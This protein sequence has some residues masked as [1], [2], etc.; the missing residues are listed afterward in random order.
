MT[1]DRR[2]QRDVEN[3]LRRSAERARDQG[4][5][6]AGMP[7][8]AVTLKDDN[9]YIHDAD[10]RVWQVWLTHETPLIQLVGRA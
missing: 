3:N 10:G 4:G 8:R 1:Y 2:Q 5:P 7:I 9:V 6:R